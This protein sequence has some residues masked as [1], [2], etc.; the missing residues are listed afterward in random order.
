MAK[1]PSKKEDLAAIRASLQK[2]MADGATVDQAF[3]TVWEK[4]PDA[5][6]RVTKRK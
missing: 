2:D 5:A 1:R 3:A 6:N 4:L